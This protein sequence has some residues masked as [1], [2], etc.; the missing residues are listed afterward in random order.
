MAADIAKLRVSIDAIDDQLIELLNRRAAFVKDVGLVKKGVTEK[1]HCYIR[2]GREAD[3]V[4]RIFKEFKK[5]AFPAQAAVGIWRII[6]CASL[7]LESKLTVSA[8]DER[9]YWLAR[10]YFASF[11]PVKK[12]KNANDVIKDIKA[13]KAQVGV[14]ALNQKWWL[15]LPQ[16]IKVF[17]CIPFALR[18][19]E[20]PEALALAKLEPEETGD[21]ISLLK[22]TVKGKVQAKHIESVFRAHKHAAQLLASAGN[23]HLL[24]V[25]GFVNAGE[26]ALR[27]IQKEAGFAI[28][29]L[30][31][32]A[33]PLKV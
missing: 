18:K 31:S 24:Q 15:N 13:G 5:G 17:A 7:A 8:T 30:G 6:I 28:T 29:P 33:V 12:Y 32:Y 21:D 2:S 20:N 1:G 10:E 22:V 27:A 25:K 23:A 19:G 9:I 3:I 14:V 26:K 4:R 11:T 16:D